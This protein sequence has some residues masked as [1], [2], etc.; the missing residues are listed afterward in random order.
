MSKKSASCYLVIKP[1]IHDY[2]TPRVRSLRVTRMT[3]KKP[4]LASGEIAVKVTLNFDEERLIAS[5]PE[6]SADV[7]VW[8]T[9]LTDML[10]SAR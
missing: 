9:A 10:T 3:A 5:I 2:G 6:V 4:S 7:D 1:D 8:N